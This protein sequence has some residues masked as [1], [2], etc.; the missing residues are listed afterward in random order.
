[1][2]ISVDIVNIHTY[3]QQMP[4]MDV[5]DT[6]KRRRSNI[7]VISFI[8]CLRR[9]YRHIAFKTI[10]SQMTFMTNCIAIS[11]EYKI[12]AFH[13]QHSSSHC[14]IDSTINI[15]IPLLNGFVLRMLSTYELLIHQ[16]LMYWSIRII[17][18]I[19]MTQQI[20]SRVFQLIRM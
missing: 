15:Q 11:K 16:K 9:V 2:L 10:D 17:S 7:I 12:R 1:M 6:V 8:I 13:F 14:V 19:M 5:V 4:F 3:L 18:H 20:I